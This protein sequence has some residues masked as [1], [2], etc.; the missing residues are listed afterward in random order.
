MDES[1]FFFKDVFGRIL[2]GYLLRA[3][4]IN[5]LFNRLVTVERRDRPDRKKRKDDTTIDP[6]TVTHGKKNNQLKS[7]FNLPPDYASKCQCKNQPVVMDKAEAEAWSKTGS[8][9]LDDFQGIR[10]PPRSREIVYIDR[11]F[12]LTCPSSKYAHLQLTRD[13]GGGV[14]YL[15]PCCQNKPKREIVPQSEIKIYIDEVKENVETVIPARNADDREITI[16]FPDELS[17]ILTFLSDGYIP[18]TYP[19]RN[20]VETVSMIAGV[21]MNK[22]RLG[23][24]FHEVRQT[25]LP[26]VLSQE[27]FGLDTTPEELHDGLN[28]DTLTISHLHA[29][30]EYLQTNIYVF[31]AGLRHREIHSDYNIDLVTPKSKIYYARKTYPEVAFVYQSR[32]NVYTAISFNN[33]FR[34]VRNEPITQFITT[35]YKHVSF[36]RTSS[37]ITDSIEYVHENTSDPILRQLIDV[38]GKTRIVQTKSGATFSIP[39]T[40]PYNLPL[41]EEPTLGKDS[42]LERF[43]F[44]GGAGPWYSYGGLDD[45]I[46]LLT[47]RLDSGRSTQSCL[48]NDEIDKIVEDG[49]R[50]N[51]INRKSAN[52]ITQL[53]HWAWGRSNRPPLAEWWPKNVRIVDS[54]IVRPKYYQHMIISLHRVSEWWPSITDGYHFTWNRR[55]DDKIRAFFEKEYEIIGDLSNGELPVIPYLIGVYETDNDYEDATTSRFFN[56]TD[57]LKKWLLFDRQQEEESNLG[58]YEITSLED[59]RNLSV[60]EVPIR[61]RYNNYWVFLVNIPSKS[62]IE[63]VRKSCQLVGKEMDRDYHLVVLRYNNQL[64]L[65]V[66]GDVDIERITSES[67][68]VFQYPDNTYAAIF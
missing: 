32:E 43:P 38:T 57:S 1:Y 11:G 3:N 39:P 42:D 64:Q 6:H 51:S 37:R 15:E 54:E 44:N 33:K 66:R 18:T 34:L 47:D 9:I 49:F 26:Y 5:D 67:I 63:A 62:L 29:V 21:G 58:F 13:R 25:V 35:L 28:K 10:K 2:N 46:Y 23:D 50:E 20:L 12:Y 8:F 60:K 61:L 30:E 19:G 56:G 17:T 22:A 41:I 4:A 45:Q 7:I 52:V 53:V 65:V 59:I 55:F 48:F 24:F 36:S 14:Y 27:A 68:Y 40:A 16:G 31:E